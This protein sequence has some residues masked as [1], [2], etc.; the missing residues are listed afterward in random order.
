MIGREIDPG[1]LGPSRIREITK[2]VFIEDRSGPADLPF[3][4]GSPDIPQAVYSRVTDWT[5]RDWFKIV[6]VAGKIGRSYDR[7][8]IPL[9][10]TMR[11][12]Q[13]ATGVQPGRVVIQD[14]STNTFE[15][16]QFTLEEV[17]RRK[18]APDTALFVSKAH[19]SGRWLR[20]LQVHLPDAEIRTAIHDYAYDGCPVARTD[21]W[22]RETARR[23]VYAEYV[24]ITT[25][26]DLQTGRT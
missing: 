17:R 6:V 5:R 4:F 16:A 25:Y 9:A 23:R 13:V 26:P 20:T 10:H 11:D 7:T 21:W 1:D 24:R 2:T 12:G 18:I 22:R 19:D 3:M 15:D 14:H 8:G